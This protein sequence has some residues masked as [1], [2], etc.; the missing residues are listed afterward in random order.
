MPRTES[1]S[2]T[3]ST[4]FPTAA[5]KWS[6]KKAWMFCSPFAVLTF[7]FGANVCPAQKKVLQSAFPRQN[8][9]SGS[10][11]RCR[12]EL[13]VAFNQRISFV[14][15]EKQTCRP[16]TSLAF[17]STTSD[18]VQER[19][20]GFDQLVSIVGKVETGSSQSPSRRAG[21]M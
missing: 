13:L 2:P 12:S 14:V 9:S 18:P 16:E 19:R 17:Q 21:L 6:C 20:A 4:S 7:N 3:A 1:S 15:P 10:L 5:K 11:H 8:P